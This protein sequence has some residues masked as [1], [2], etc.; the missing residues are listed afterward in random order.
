MRGPFWTPITPLTGSFLHAG[1]QG[2]AEERAIASLFTPGGTRGA[3]IDP[4]M[5]DW[6]VTA[7][8]AIL[9]PE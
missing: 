9:P 1:P 2:K 8:L 4:G 3:S 7:W 5:D 6:E